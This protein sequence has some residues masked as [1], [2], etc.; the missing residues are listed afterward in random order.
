MKYRMVQDG[1]GVRHRIPINENGYV[2]VSEMV[3]HAKRVQSD[4]GREI[5]GRRSSKIVYRMESTPE[6]MYRW[7]VHPNQYDIEGID[8]EKRANVKKRTNKKNTKPT[9]KVVKVVP[10]SIKPMPIVKQEPVE[11]HIHVV[12]IPQM[13]VEML[14]AGMD[15]PKS[16]IDRFRRPKKNEYS[17]STYEKINW[18]VDEEHALRDYV[19]MDYVEKYAGDLDDARARLS[20][21]DFDE[22]ARNSRWKYDD[23]DLIIESRRRALDEFHRYYVDGTTYN[24]KAKRRFRR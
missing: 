19:E 14:T 21:D 9:A 15:K 4:T 2:P 8:T 10:V 5:D 6:E 22:I 13:P 17:A 16:I 24:Q 7:W 12:E 20:D 1:R 3:E 11:Q 23:R 18:K